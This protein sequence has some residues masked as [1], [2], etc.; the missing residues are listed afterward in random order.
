M[1]VWARLIQLVRSKIHYGVDCWVKHDCKLAK[2]SLE[3]LRKQ[4][5]FYSRGHALKLFKKMHAR[6]HF[7]NVLMLLGETSMF[8]S[9]PG[10]STLSK[11]QC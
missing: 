4:I 9:S 7:F 11:P 6:T 3:A 1:S 5:A 2:Q 8:M 10:L